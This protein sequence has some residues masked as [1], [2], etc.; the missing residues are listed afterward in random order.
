MKRLVLPLIMLLLLAVA[1]DFVGEAQ[2]TVPVNVEIAKQ[3][4]PG[5]KHPGILPAYRMPGEERIAGKQDAASDYRAMHPQWYAITKPP[6]ASFRPMKE[7]EPM[8]A[9]IITYSDYMPG[10]NGTAQTLAD[11]AIHSIPAGEVWVVVR[12]ESAKNDLID[13]MK[14]GGVTDQQ[15]ADQV[16]FFNIENDAIWTIDFG[17]FPL[18]DDAAGEMVW[19]DFRYYHQRYRDDAIPTRLANLVGVNT[20]RSPFDFE[21][22]NF[23]ADGDE[24]CYFSERVYQYTGM[25]FDDVESIM[26]THYGCKKAVVLKDITDDGTGHIDMFFKLASKHSAFIGDYTVVSD[27]TNKQR[28]DDNVDILHGLKYSDGSPGI[29]VYRI[30]FPNPSDGVPRTFI[31]STFFVSADG[32]YKVNLWPM[33]TV[34]KDLEAEALDAWEQGLP[35]WVHQGILSDQISLYSGAVHCVTRTIPAVA[36]ANAIPDGECVNGACEGEAGAYNG[37]CIS[38]YEPTSG[39]WGPEWEC[40][41]NICNA[42]GCGIP[43]SCGDGTCDDDE[44]CFSCAQDCGCGDEQICDP[45]SRE[46]FDDEC[47]DITNVGCCD[48]DD[49]LVYCDGGL[50]VVSSC[51]GEGCG[52]S[53]AD[54]LYDCGGDGQDPSG[55]A[56]LDCAGYG[57]PPGCD[58]KECGD[59]G[60]GY[61]CGEC[62]D[63]EECVKGSCELLVCS[64]DGKDC[65][66]D[67]CGG[68]CGECDEGIECLEG[69]CECTPSCDEKTCGDDGCGGLC[70]ECEEGFTC[71]ES[72]ACAAVSVEPDEDVITEED[73]TGTDGGGKKSGGCSTDASGSGSTGMG[74]VLFALLFAVLAV[75]RKVTA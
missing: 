32:Q 69:I 72:F 40:L 47:G 73:T 51:Q 30:P 67:G 42:T 33:Y 6:P 59:N 57:F 74:L 65:G 50:L 4:E 9:N 41:C 66:D 12:A 1:C 70:G 56:L 25:S 23:Q 53:S 26:Q 29:K 64:C 46:C 21:G 27:P 37:A 38:D 3:V 62:S 22:G 35:G 8:Q 48:G 71:D 54:S 17:P 49:T 20:Y 16:K 43:A 28:M 39:C 31:N 44:T 36:L 5:F 34:D 45:A 11:I 14:A 10:D 61:S 55:T 13:R 75:R 63:G 19:T 68:S 7:W 24:F 2:E 58:D 18:V 52:W 15:I 60:Q